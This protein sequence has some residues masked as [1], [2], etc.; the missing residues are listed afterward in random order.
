MRLNGKLSLNRELPV[1]VPQ[2]SMPRKLR[3]TKP[4]KKLNV[5][6]LRL[7]PVI[8]RK[9]SLNGTSFATAM[10]QFKHPVTL[11]AAAG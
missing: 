5:A 3:M 9:R 2:L 10:Q 6:T 1:F 8:S 11:S 4:M 7:S